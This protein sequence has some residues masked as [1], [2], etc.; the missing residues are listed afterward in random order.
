[1]SHLMNH[2]SQEQ[3][4]RLTFQ[5]DN[6]ICD[7]QFCWCKLNLCISRNNSEVPTSENTVF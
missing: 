3:K 2:S 5:L 7:F 1:M 6:L 4:V